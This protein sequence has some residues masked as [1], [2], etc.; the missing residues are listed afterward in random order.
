M[1]R[2]FLSLL[3]A[4]FASAAEKP[5]TPL[6]DGKS[7]SGWTS[8]TGGK[9]GD[10][11]EVVDGTIHRKGQGGDLISEKEYGDFELEF[12]WMISAGGNSGLKYR[13]R[14]TAAG[15]IGA[16]YQVLDDA[17]HPNGKVGDTSAGSL[18]EVIAPDPKKVLHPAGEW[19]R[20]KIVV[21]GSVIEHWLNGALVLKADTSTPAW[22]AA[23]KDS[24]FARVEGF[25]GPGPGHLLLQDHGAEVRFRALRI[26]ELETP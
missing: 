15:W 17:G 25:A 20:S 5:W 19:N 8:A 12:E 23:K 14:K 26:R 13:V 3:L 2:L 22:E 9:P 10:G 18:Y 7:L 1:R 11:W 6:F 16:E 21:R 24:K 4:G